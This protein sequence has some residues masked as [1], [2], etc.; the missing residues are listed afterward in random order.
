MDNKETTMEN[1]NGK[2]N[3]PINGRCL[4]FTLM[5]LDN[6]ICNK[7]ILVPINGIMEIFPVHVGVR[8]LVVSIA[9]YTW[10]RVWAC[11]ALIHLSIF[12]SA[13]RLL[14]KFNYFFLLH[15][16]APWQYY[17]SL[18]ISHYSMTDLLIF[19]S[20]NYVST[21]YLFYEQRVS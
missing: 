10:Y 3:N 2:D 11:R 8:V 9:A 19:L 14:G 1:T 6:G 16:L 7:P 20:F 18:V 4:T 17:P 5:G 15:L 13:R 12:H 21:S